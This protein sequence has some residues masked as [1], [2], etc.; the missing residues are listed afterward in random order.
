MTNSILQKFKKAIHSDLKA[1][2]EGNYLV[3][4]EEGSG[5]KIKELK[6]NFKNK[7]DALIIQQK[8]NE[9]LAIKNLFNQQNLPSCDFIVLISKNKE[10]NIYFCEIKSIINENN[11]KEAMKQIKS[12]EIFFNFLCKS[13]SFIYDK[14]FEI[15]QAKVKYIMLYPAPFSQKQESTPQKHHQL[16]CEPI[17]VDEITGKF[18][19]DNAYDFFRSL[20]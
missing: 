10:L 11:Q 14:A 1:R 20:Q 3:V 5:S 18:Q 7:D 8:D 9:C 17:K 16:I 2:E 19:N 6:F 15:Q 4:T 12:S 13:Y